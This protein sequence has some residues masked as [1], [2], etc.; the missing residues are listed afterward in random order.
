MIEVFKIIHGIDKIN[1]GKFFGVD[2][3]RRTR[4]SF[5][6]KIKRDINSNVGLNFF[7]RRVINY[8]NKL[9]YVVVG[10]KS[11]DTFKMNL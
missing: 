3:D 11:L 10:C 2:E 8:W 9:S 5:C 1:L 4:Y 7:T 6:L